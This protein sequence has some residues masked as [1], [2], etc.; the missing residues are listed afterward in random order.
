[1]ENGSVDSEFSPTIFPA[2]Q[3]N[4]SRFREGEVFTTLSVLPFYCV[5]SISRKEKG[6]THTDTRSHGRHKSVRNIFGTFL[7]LSPPFSVPTIMTSGLWKSIFLA[8]TSESGKGRKS[9][10]PGATLMCSELFSLRKPSPLAALS[11]YLHS[12]FVGDPVTGIP[13][14]ARGENIIDF[15]FGSPVCVESEIKQLR[16]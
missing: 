1:M 15:Q 5:H 12:Q 6:S 16:D 4:D 14:L 11:R 10:T 2:N 9:G 7:S 13:L 8:A 3:H